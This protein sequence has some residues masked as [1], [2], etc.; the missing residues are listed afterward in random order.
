MNNDEKVKLGEGREIGSWV[1]SGAK[2]NGGIA[3]P[4]HYGTKQG[5]FHKIT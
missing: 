4:K 3:K 1:A 2:G 5:H